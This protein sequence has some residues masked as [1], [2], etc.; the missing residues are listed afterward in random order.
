ML[1]S[2]GINLV[3]LLWDRSSL[4]R[5][6]NCPNDR[7]IK[8]EKKFDLNLRDRRFARFEKA[9]GMPSLI[10]FLE[11]FSCRRAH[12]RSILR[13]EI[14]SVELLYEMSSDR[15]FLVL[16]K[17]FS[18]SGPVRL[19]FER[20]TS[21]KILQRE[22]KFGGLGLMRPTTERSRCVSP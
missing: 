17:K 18:G 11:R 5:L 13:P 4:W 22:K 20:L 2:D 7:G 3:R 9:M 19:L 10:R 14:G 8:L 16:A 15:W 6:L 1:S 21:S 12:E